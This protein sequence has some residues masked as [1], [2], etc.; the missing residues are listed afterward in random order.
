M[1]KTDFI[2]ISNH[3]KSCIKKRK[4]YLVF[5]EIRR[6]ETLNR[7]IKNYYTYLIYMKIDY[8]T[9]VYFTFNILFFHY[10]ILQV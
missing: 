9:Y 7:L 8:Y 6:N 1:I 4:L 3:I 5:I 2:F 10:V